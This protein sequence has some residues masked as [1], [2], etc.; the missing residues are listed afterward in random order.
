[1]RQDRYGRKALGRLPAT[2]ACCM[3]GGRSS[4]PGV[5]MAGQFRLMA[6][7]TVVT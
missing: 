3:P 7:G 2:G 5:F 4:L 6:A 1:M